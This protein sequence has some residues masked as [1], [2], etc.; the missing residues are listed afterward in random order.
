MSE[1]VKKVISL[2]EIRERA[3]GRLIEIPDWTPGSW[4]TVR[5]KDI[6]MTPYIMSLDNLPN[7][8]KKTAAEAFELDGGI[9]EKKALEMA[10]NMEM[11]EIAE[12]MPIIDGVCKE[13]LVDPLFDDIQELLPLTMNQ[14]MF[15]FNIAMGKVDQLNSFR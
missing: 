6:D 13:V 5:I 12:M 15:I 4:I 8:L 10:K 14:K 7:I 11:A 9:D 1:D 3:K 2:D